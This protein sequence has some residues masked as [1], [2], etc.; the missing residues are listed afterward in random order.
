MATLANGGDGKKPAHQIGTDGVIKDSQQLKEA[1]QG[2]GIATLDQ[3][4]VRAGQWNHNPK[5]GYKATQGGMTMLSAMDE[6][7]DMAG[8]DKESGDVS[9]T[10]QDDAENKKEWAVVEHYRDAALVVKIALEDL[11]GYTVKEKKQCF[12]SNLSLCID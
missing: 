6:V 1:N 9:D 12:G 11:A 10:E 2:P 7:M 8:D 4:N 5:L 3:S